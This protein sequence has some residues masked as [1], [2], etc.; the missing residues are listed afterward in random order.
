MLKKTVAEVKINKKISEIF[1]DFYFYL[2]FF[3]FAHSY[4]SHSIVAGGLL[5]IS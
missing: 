3:A 4:Y 5:E 1:G 2:G